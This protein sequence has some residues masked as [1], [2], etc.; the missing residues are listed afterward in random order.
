MNKCVLGTGTSKYIVQPEKSIGL[1]PI[2]EVSKIFYKEV[3]DQQRQLESLVKVESEEAERMEHDRKEEVKVVPK[4]CAHRDKFI[5]IVSM[6]E[7][8]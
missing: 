4:F 8:M 3:E 2:K 7:I 5:E 1:K 6:L